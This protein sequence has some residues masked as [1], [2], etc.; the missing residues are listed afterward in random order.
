MQ[1]INQVR[2]SFRLLKTEIIL[3]NMEF[4]IPIMNL[5]WMN[6]IGMDQLDIAITQASFMVIMVIMDVPMGLLADAF[7]RKWANVIG[8]LILSIGFLGYAF[9]QTMWQVIAAEVVLAVGMSCTS[10]ADGP[11]LEEYCN[12]LD[13]DYR[14]ESAKIQKWTPLVMALAM[15]LGGFIGA[16]SPRLTIVLTAMPFLVGAILGMF[17]CEDKRIREPDAKHPLRDV[18]TVVSYCF[19][20]HD[21]LAATIWARTVL[22][23][24]THTLVWVTTPILLLA[25]VPVWLV[26][27]GWAVNNVGAS[28]GAFAA[29]KWGIRLGTHQA[30]VIPMCVLVASCT[31]LGLFPNIATAFLFAVFGAIKGWGIAIMPARVQQLAPEKIK[32]SVNSVSTTLSRIVYIPLVILIGWAGKNVPS[33]ALML[34]AAIFTVLGVSVL[35]KLRRHT[36]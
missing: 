10:G 7:S 34:N 36:E 27:V 11:L 33:N 18:R 1:N 32:S 13:R 15:T 6:Y 17:L 22:A 16:V 29:S 35:P 9:T 5:F 19:R 3:G 24:S 28:L 21:E 12:K 2:R 26:G 20:G 23:A 14:Y 30:F 31:I 8:D 4:M 25:G